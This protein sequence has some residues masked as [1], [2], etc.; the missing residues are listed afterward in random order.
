MAEEQIILTFEI[1]HDEATKDLT[2]V[3]KSI[4]ALKKQQL[5]LN[6][7]FKEGKIT[8]DQ[9]IKSNLQ[10]QKAIKSEN[11]QKKV[12]TKL[13]V[14]E[15]NSRN[16]M[17][18][19]VADL[20]KEYNNLNL[21]TAVGKKR[22]DELQKELA[23][24]N[25]ELNKGSQAAGQFKDNIGNYPQSL[26]AAT[27]QI[28]PFGQSVEGISSSMGK[29]LTPAGAAVGL[30]TGLATLYAS[31][32]AGAKDLSFATGVLSGSFRAATNSFGDFISE[33]TGGDPEG[34]GG[35]LSKIAVAFSA[36]FLGISNTVSGILVANAEKTL[37]ELE[38]ISIDAQGIGKIFEKQAEDARR[39]RDD[40]EQALQDRLAASK[41]V[42]AQLLANLQV[43]QVTQERV[44]EQLQTLAK[45]SGNDPEIR[46]QIKSAQAEVRDLQEEING[47]LTE[48]ISAR[49]AI[50]QLIDDT[51]A[52]NRRAANQVEVTTDDPLTGAFQTQADVRIDIEARMQKDLKDRKDKAATE[53]L[54]RAKKGAELEIQVERDKAAIISGFIGSLADLAEQDSAEH[55]FLASAQ[56]LINT[57]LAAT[58]ALASGSEINPIFG[59]VSAAAAIASG[60]A[61]VAKINGVEFAEGG[62]TGPGHKMQPVG[63]VHAD[64]YVVPKRIVNNP[65][66]RSSIANLEAMRVRPYADGGLVSNSIT[67]PVNQQLDIANILKNMP[68]PVLS[69]KEVTKIQDRIKVKENLSKR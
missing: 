7:S 67:Q 18:Q 49:K 27:E 38:I 64:E 41:D 66:A 22:S 12:L 4:L 58:A 37:K 19:R 57:Y 44:I 55:K 25:A 43:R 15:S 8:E 24:L 3:E 14:T 68:A 63:I 29:F 5:E 48:N 50:L 21:T 11:E 54:I 10:L 16:A 40:E 6:K 32:A 13:L 26:A 34:G 60:L 9:Y 42:E 35:F 46:K 23:Q 30:L 59:I 20:N 31:S 2:S 45:L 51:N 36:A 61:S 65:A 28:K 62:W 47:K 52:A 53:D 17:R 69:V 1:D 39:I 33:L 56:A